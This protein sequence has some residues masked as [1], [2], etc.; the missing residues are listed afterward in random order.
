VPVLHQSTDTIGHRPAGQ[1]EFTPDMIDA[2]FLGRL[3]V[4]PIVPARSEL[5]S[6]MYPKAFIGCKRGHGQNTGSFGLFQVGKR[7]PIK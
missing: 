1:D 4:R 5:D 3:F 2:K 7:Y 6:S